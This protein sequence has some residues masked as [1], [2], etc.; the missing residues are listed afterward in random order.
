[1]QVRCKFCGKEITTDHYG[2]TKH[3][4]MCLECWGRVKN[5]I[6]SCVSICNNMRPDT[7][8]KIGEVYEVD[9][10]AG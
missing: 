10:R 5:E 4:S 3:G 6:S 9:N 2:I 1:M 7:G 8:K